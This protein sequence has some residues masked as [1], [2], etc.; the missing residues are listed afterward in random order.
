MN[1]APDTVNGS[2]RWRIHGLTP[3]FRLEEVWELPRPDG[4][5]DFPRRER[6][7]HGLCPS[8]CGTRRQHQASLNRGGSSAVTTVTADW[9]CSSL[10]PSHQQRR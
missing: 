3:D 6:E 4:P 8:Q 1:E 5:D 9:V 2:R 7:R 10:Q